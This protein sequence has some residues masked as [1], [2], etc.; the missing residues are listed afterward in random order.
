MAGLIDFLLSINS[1]SLGLSDLLY[2]IMLH[3]SGFF[4]NFVQG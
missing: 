4:A 3:D 1:A 2:R